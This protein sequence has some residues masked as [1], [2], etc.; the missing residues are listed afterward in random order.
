M[1]VV[2][3]ACVSL[4]EDDVF[5]FWHNA[6]SGA[7]VCSLHHGM[8]WS[9]CFSGIFVSRASAILDLRDPPN[10]VLTSFLLGESSVL[11]PSCGGC[12]LHG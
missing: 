7:T 12:H 6:F 9:F 8:R 10:M 11:P 1:R 4:D 2:H 5:L 3:P